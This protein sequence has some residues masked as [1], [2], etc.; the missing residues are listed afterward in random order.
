MTMPTSNIHFITGNDEPQIFA[1][2]KALFQNFAGDNPDPF[3]SDI[4]TVK[5]GESPANAL[6][7]LMTSIMTPSFFG[8][9]KIVWLKHFPGFSD[10]G[11]VKNETAVGKMLHGLAERCLAGLPD[12]VILIMDGVD[13]DK[14]LA[15]WKACQK[16]AQIQEFLKPD[17]KNKFWRDDMRTCIRQTAESKGMH[18]SGDVIDALID[19][20]G[21]NTNLVATELDKLLCYCGQNNMPT[22]QDIIDI[23]TP[24]G[25]EQ[26]WALNDSIGNRNLQSALSA[27]ETLTGRDKDPDGRAR[28]LIFGAFNTFSNFLNVIAFMEEHKMRRSDELKYYLEQL[29]PEQKKEFRSQGDTITGMHPY[30]AKIMADQAKRYSKKEMHQAIISLRNAL[31]QTTTS[32]IRPLVA[33]ENAIISI[34]KN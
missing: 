19:T 4:I 5:E 7:Q 6:S 27:I 3:S 25:E 34:L 32:D 16:F 28:A 18:L 21:C 31:W 12:G 24:C 22:I 13:C 15:F 10:E 14:K 23:C 29:S 26:A 2:A 9:D 20:L 33:L 8:G 30:R 1:A 11:T 17:M